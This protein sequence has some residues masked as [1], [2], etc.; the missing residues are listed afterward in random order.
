MK[1]I[2]LFFQ[3][4]PMF[5]RKRRLRPADSSLSLGDW[6][7]RVYECYLPH[8]R[9]YTLSPDGKCRY[10]VNSKVAC[11]SLKKAVTG[12]LPSSEGSDIHYL[13]TEKGLPAY[14]TC[15]PLR[16]KARFRLLYF[17]FCAQSL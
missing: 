17:Y 6:L 11:S 16:G 4:L 14:G 12:L 10:L 15:S 2:I 7:R 3:L 8:F 9:E 1:R 5:L 13:V